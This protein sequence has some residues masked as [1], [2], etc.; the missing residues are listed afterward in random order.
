MDDPTANG[1]PPPEGRLG[2]VAQLVEAL[3]SGS[4]ALVTG[5]TGAA[6]L[7]DEVSCKLAKRRTRVLRVRPPLD[8]RAFMAQVRPAGPGI[9]DAE[10]AQGF[11]RLV[12]PDATCDRI[13]LLVEDAH[14]LHP[15]TLHYIEL[16]LRSGPYLQVALFGRPGTADELALGASSLLNE[17]LSLRLALKP[18]RFKARPAA[19]AGGPAPPVAPAP[20]SRPAGRA[21]TA[22]ARAVT[23]CLVLTIWAFRLVPG[24]VSEDVA[25]FDAPPATVA[26][27]VEVPLAA[28]APPPLPE[29][30]PEPSLA[31]AAPEAASVPR[32]EP[33]P[34]VPADLV[35]VA[36]AVPEPGP[37]SAAPEA[38][39]LSAS[40]EA[41]PI[42]PVEPQLVARADPASATAPEPE[43]EP[44]PEP[45]SMPASASAPEPRREPPPV[46]TVAALALAPP[47]PRTQNRVL[48][49]H[50]D[51]AAAQPTPRQDERR[52]LDIV[53]RAQSGEDPS[54]GD[55]MFLRN[56]CR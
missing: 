3:A 42:L 7:L 2:L 31:S 21:A 20:G 8:L 15:A 26:L 56:G 39:L 17:R 29:R 37:A 9:A 11:R 16:A 35:L 33:Q 24:S 52:C 36:Y 13:A 55:R 38:G 50:A 41:A 46:P 28:I 4:S 48:P 1:H 22:L 44:E 23:A 12:E 51:R 43:P 25:E 5:S 49:V 27:A 10:I 45:D 19:A 18:L 40:P 30:T 54:Y 47:S 6:E 34:A 53:L 32:I 14:F